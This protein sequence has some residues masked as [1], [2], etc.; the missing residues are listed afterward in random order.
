MEWNRIE[1]GD[2]TATQEKQALTLAKK[3]LFADSLR[4]ESPEV[5]VIEVQ[6]NLTIEC[7]VT[8]GGETTRKERES[9]KMPA[10]VI[11]VLRGD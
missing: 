2:R 3:I 6:L 7:R 11:M 10:A 4:P 8:G 9:D 1:Y 5:M